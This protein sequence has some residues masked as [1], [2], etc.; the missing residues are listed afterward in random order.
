MHNNTKRKYW[1]KEEIEDLRIMYCD[2]G[3]DTLEISK[4]LK[5]TNF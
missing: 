3:M 2:K 1:T 5:R 4:K